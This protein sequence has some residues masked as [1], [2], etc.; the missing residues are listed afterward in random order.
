M[1]F[2]RR[3]GRRGGAAELWPAI[4]MVLATWLA[5]SGLLL[6]AR[7]TVGATQPL[8]WQQLVLATF[9]LLAAAWLSHAAVAWPRTRR[10]PGAMV[11]GLLTSV[12]LLF[13]AISLSHHAGSNLLAG[14]IFLP[15]VMEEA[16]AW[17]SILAF[18][19]VIHR[20]ATNGRAEARLLQ[21]FTRT[22][23]PLGEETIQG[24]VA[25][26]IEPGSRMAAT[27]IA[28]CPPFVERPQ[29]EAHLEPQVSGALKVTQLYAH[30]ARIELRL[31]QVSG[32]E[33]RVSVRFTARQVQALTSSSVAH[34]LGSS[35]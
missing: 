31:P 22:I 13:W 23:T 32:T 28:F 2:G 8:R 20:A 6:A 33:E 34:K 4:G 35:R 1:L 15:L 25:L 14:A 24:R 10:A 16:W 12:G 29:F 11:C 30:G 21:Q 9:G 17:R 3:L 18:A 19:P 27:H 5:C 26:R 7:T